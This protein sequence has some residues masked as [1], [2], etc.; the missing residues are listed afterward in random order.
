MGQHRQ[1]C[2]HWA[3]DAAA[4]AHRH[5]P[6]NNHCSGAESL[7]GR[8]EVGTACRRVGAVCRRAG[9]ASRLVGEAYKRVF[10]VCRR[11]GTACRRVGTAYKR[12]GAATHA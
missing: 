6:L 9:A 11:V 2:N 3:A 8:S 12:V 5:R 4:R 1:S 10:A 7:A